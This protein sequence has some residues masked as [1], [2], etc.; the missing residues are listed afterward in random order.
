LDI[1]NAALFFR[2]IPKT[3]LDIRNIFFQISENIFPD[4]QNTR[5]F[6]IS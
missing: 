4:I 6:W 1:H 5:F 2:D 3:F